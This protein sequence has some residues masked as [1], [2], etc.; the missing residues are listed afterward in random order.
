MAVP[1]VERYKV[2]MYF[3]KCMGLLPFS[4]TVNE[5]GLKLK[6][7]RVAEKVGRL[8]F[9]SLLVATISAMND[10]YW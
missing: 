8:F 10:F 2:L 3:L 4:K 1:F 7:S 9:L 5:N 6:Q